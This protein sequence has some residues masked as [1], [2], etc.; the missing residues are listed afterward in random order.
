MKQLKNPS[1]TRDIEIRRG[2]FNTWTFILSEGGVP[3]YESYPIDSYLGCLEEVI[4][5]LNKDTIEIIELTK[6]TLKSADRYLNIALIFNLIAL[7][8]IL[9]SLVHRCIS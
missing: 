1:P 5:Y 4:R 9:M 7:F 8:L 3:I 2:N 6:K